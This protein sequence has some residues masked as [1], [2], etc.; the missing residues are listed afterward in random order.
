MDDTWADGGGENLSAFYA[1]EVYELSGKQ[2][3]KSPEVG[4]AIIESDVGC[5]IRAGGHSSQPFDRNRFL[6]S[7]DNHLQLAEQQMQ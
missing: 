1:S 4:K 3:L 7:A 5:H 6:E 2:G